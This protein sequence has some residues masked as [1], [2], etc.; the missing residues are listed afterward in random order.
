MFATCTI[1]FLLTIMAIATIGTL[2]TLTMLT[3]LTT[4]WPPPCSPW[5][6]WP[7]WPPWPPWLQVNR[8]EPEQ[9]LQVAASVADRL[10]AT[11]CSVHTT[12][13]WWG[14]FENISFNSNWLQLI[15]QVP[16][17]HEPR[18]SQQTTAGSHQHWRVSCVCLKKILNQK[19]EREVERNLIFAFQD[20]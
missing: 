12:Q 19:R 8:L 3:S 6:C 9:C 17:R 1:L 20:K 13:P 10:T 7:P 16:R 11:Q 2:T 14:I 15:F 18:Q 4:C 5:P